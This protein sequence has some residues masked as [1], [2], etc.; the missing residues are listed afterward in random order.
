M[1]FHKI[2]G[3]INITN[4][5]LTWVL[6]MAYKAVNAYGTV[7]VSLVGG[8]SQAFDVLTGTAL[9]ESIQFLVEVSHSRPA[10]DRPV[11][12]LREIARAFSRFTGVKTGACLWDE[13]SKQTLI[14]VC[15]PDGEPYSVNDE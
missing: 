5:Q 3:D 2:F 10:P 1:F 6:A 12:L 11:V 7:Y 9:P 13:D 15:L 14:Y 8:L 4:D